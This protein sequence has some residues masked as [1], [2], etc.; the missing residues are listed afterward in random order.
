[1]SSRR[2]LALYGVMLSALCGALLVWGQQ[3]SVRAAET[4][5]VRAAGGSLTSGA[6]GPAVTLPLEVVNAHGLGAVTVL[7]GYDP[8]YLR[9]VACQRNPIFD[10]GLCNTTHDR[11]G[12]GIPDAVLF[13]VVS[14]Y[15]VNATGAP[16]ALVNITWQAVAAVPDA[17]ITVLAV[18]VE[19]FTDTDG[20]PLAHTAQDGQLTL[21]PEPPPLTAT[22]TPTASPTSTATPTATASPPGRQSYLP[23]LLRSYSGSPSPTPTPTGTVT[24]TPS[25]QPN[26]TC[27]DWC[28]PGGAPGW[29]RQTVT[30]DWPVADWRGTINFVL[31]Q[32][33]VS[34]TATA[35]I[36]E[37]PD[38]AT[39]RID[40]FFDGQWLLACKSVAVCRP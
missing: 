13:N 7:V 40:A 4:A 25:R 39:V 28:T 27:S 15:G 10:V 32:E 29:W 18:Q 6:P 11:N 2:L 26:F 37:A 8:A 31:Y 12:D 23:V 33:L 16:V 21:L 35:A 9:G 5:I 19:T 17:R 34:E 20:Q 1:M 36:V 24:P 22:P 30:S 3:S 14:L 38:N